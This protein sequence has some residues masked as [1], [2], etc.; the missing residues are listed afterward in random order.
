MNATLEQI[1]Q[2]FKNNETVCQKVVDLF[3]LI[4][5]RTRFRILCLLSEGEFC[6]GDIVDTI[7]ISNFSNISQ[8][9]RLLTM[10]GIVDR[11]R[12]GKR[13]LY[14]LIDERV[15]EIILYLHNNFL[16]A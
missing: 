8:Q 16:N 6:V 9:L 13:I 5:N 1:K 10:A 14:K 15:K 7:Q 3:A 2:H 11:R 4:S 12:D